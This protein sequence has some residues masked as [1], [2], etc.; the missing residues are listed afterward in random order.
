M[1]DLL[2]R[3][4]ELINKIEELTHSILEIQTKEENNESSISKINELINTRQNVMDEIDT[5]DEK[6]RGN[7]SRLNNVDVD[8][9]TSKRHIELSIKESLKRA[10]D[11]D[12]KIK[13]NTEKDITLI[14]KNIAET[15][16]RLQT[17]DFEINEEDKKPIGYFL[18]K[19]S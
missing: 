2:K 10:I 11:M 8:I 5:I 12:N 4:L 9:L 19:K 17:S 1:I 6:M 13:L 3:K 18:N 7:N 15:E 14:R 16:K